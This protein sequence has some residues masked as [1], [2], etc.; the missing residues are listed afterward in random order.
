M[1]LSA[2]LLVPAVLSSSVMWSVNARAGFSVSDGKIY[3]GN[4]DEFVM[5]GINHAHTWFTDNLDLTLDGIASTGAN[6]IRVVLS[7]GDRW[8]EIRE[9]DVAD[10]IAKVKEKNM[11]A[12][13]EV[14]DTTGYPE[15]KNASTISSATDYWIGLKSVLV[16]QE[17]F[18]IINI[19]NEPYGNDFNPDDYVHDH[20]N[21]IKRLRDEGFTHALMV[22]APNWGQDWEFVMRDRADEIFQSDPDKNTIFSVHM[23]EVFDSKEI[24]DSYFTTFIENGLPLVVGEFAATHKEFDVDEGSIMSLAATYNLG[25]IGWS[26][27]GNGAGYGDIDIVSSWSTHEL[28]PWGEILVNDEYGIRATSR[29]ATIFGS[30]GSDDRPGDNASD[31]EVPEASVNTK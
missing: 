17:D 6:T 14:H 12:V 15:D 31:G 22:D 21:S 11:I 2:T 16:G 24:V 8:N 19:A 13:L 5:R 4:G 1:K 9:N 27:K 23:Y 3:E 20:Q 25:Y 28:T 29:L 10:I 7:S 30:S 26:W 18:V